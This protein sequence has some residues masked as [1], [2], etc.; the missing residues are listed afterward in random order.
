MATP[1][2]NLYAAADLP[3][4]VHHQYPAAI[5]KVTQTAPLV[6]LRD[7][8]VTLDDQVVRGVS[9]TPGTR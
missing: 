5:N 9:F 6:Q 3:G 8:R 2:A 7:A 4:D 1:N